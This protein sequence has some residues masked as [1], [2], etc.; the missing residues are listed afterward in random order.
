M[1]DSTHDLVTQVLRAW[2]DL[3]APWPGS[4]IKVYIELALPA[5]IVAVADVDQVGR[6]GSMRVRS[7]K[8]MPVPEANE[9]TIRSFVR[10]LYG[11][12]ERLVNESVSVGVKF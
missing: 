11:N 10:D 7:T 12:V 1:N 9:S 8:F 2:K 3:Q 6:K 5:M 4:K